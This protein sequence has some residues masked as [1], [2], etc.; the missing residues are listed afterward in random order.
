MRAEA[1]ELGTWQQ[2]QIGDG[3]V[4]SPHRPLLD[5][6]VASLSRSL[7]IEKPLHS[8]WSLCPPPRAINNMSYADVAAKGPKQSPEEVG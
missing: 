7:V 2:P 1:R 4:L 5:Q 8:F 6:I 3:I